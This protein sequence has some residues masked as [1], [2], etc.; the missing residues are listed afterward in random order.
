MKE[1][2]TSFEI[3]WEILVFCRE[4]RSLTS[5]INRCDLNSKIGQQHID[6]LTTKGYLNRHQ[7]NTKTTYQSTTKAQ[8]YI[9]LFTQLYKGLF[10]NTP[11]FKLS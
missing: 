11:G 3:Y 10:E 4:P 5:I 6:L 8:D 1:R 9:Q 2:R 7:T